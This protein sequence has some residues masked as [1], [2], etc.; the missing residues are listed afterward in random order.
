MDR[1]TKLAE[2]SRVRSYV[3]GVNNTLEHIKQKLALFLYEIDAHSNGFVVVVVPAA[4]HLLLLY[5]CFI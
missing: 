2:L 1:I 3:Q 5:A 4:I